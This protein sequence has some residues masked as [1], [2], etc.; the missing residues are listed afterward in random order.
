[1]K[2]IACDVA[3]PEVDVVHTCVNALTADGAVIFDNVFRVEFVRLMHQAFACRYLQPGSTQ[4]DQPGVDVGHRRQMDTVR[5]S[6]IF[7]DP[8]VYA[9]DALLPGI[10]ACLG[11]QAI[12]EN[13]GAVTAFPGARA[14]H[15]HRDGPPLF[16]ETGL[17]ALLP[18]YA[19]VVGIPLI[20]MNSVTGTT[21]IWPGSHRWQS[22]APARARSEPLIADIP[23]G[24]CLVW[25]YRVLHGG[26]AHQSTFIRPLLYLTYARSWYRDP[27][28]Y[29]GRR[30]RL[31]LDQDLLDGIPAAHRALFAHVT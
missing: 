14:Q 22:D 18:A 7:A 17:S 1:M 30:S 4:P 23:A 21:A 8:R 28:N 24:S 31:L 10:H 25:D 12:L 2:R 5:L 11:G 20:D 27:V 9:N 16:T 26:T 15:V 6:G 19:I 3:S 29:G 13:F